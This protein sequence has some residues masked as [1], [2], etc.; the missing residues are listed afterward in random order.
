MGQEYIDGAVAVLLRR[1]DAR[2]DGAY[3][4]L[5]REIYGDLAEIARKH[6][7]PLAFALLT[8]SYYLKD[9]QS[10]INYPVFESPE[11]AVEALATL[12]DYYTKS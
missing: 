4:R 8:Q 12:R 7:K 2:Y 1:A 6:N 10:R 11:D 9:V 3:A 5:S